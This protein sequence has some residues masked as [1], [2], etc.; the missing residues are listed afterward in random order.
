MFFGMK[1]GIELE[2]TAEGIHLFALC[3]LPATANILFSGYYQAALQEWLAYLITFLRSFLFYLTALFLCTRN[4]MQDFWFIFVVVEMLTI[5]FWVPVASLRGG[6]LQLK[7]IRVENAK[8][9]VID[10]GRQDIHEIVEQFQEFSE[11]HGADARQSMYIALTI[12]EICCA[13]VDRFREKMGRIY[14]QVTAVVEDGDVTLHLRDNAMAYNPFEEDT[15]GISLEEGKQLE[16]VGLR[17][18]QKKAKEFYYRSYSGFNTLV[19][20]L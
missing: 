7:G 3:V 10:S 17:I 5:I 8:T 12:E 19:I 20:R 13:L 6:I 15:E 14:I 2:Y 9:V 18:V 4:G 16:L 11:A 1:S